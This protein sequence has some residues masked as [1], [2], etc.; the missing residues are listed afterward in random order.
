[1]ISTYYSY[2]VKEWK[3]NGKLF[4]KKKRLKYESEETLKKIA[5]H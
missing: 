1:M 2:Q 3:A 5:K 4:L